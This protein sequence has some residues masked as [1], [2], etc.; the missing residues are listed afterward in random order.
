MK[1]IMRHQFQ[2]LLGTALLGLALSTATFARDLPDFTTLAEQNSPAVVNI[3]TEQKSLLQRK[4]PKGFSA[5]DLPEDSPLNDLFKHFFGEGG[6]D[7]GDRDT[8]SL[9]SGFVV[10]S[11]GYIL[12]N[13]HVVADADEIQV[14]FSDRRTYQAKVI[15]SDRGSDVALIKIEATGLPTVKIGKSNDLKVGEWVL[16]I[17]SPF[18]FDHTVT[19]GI[20]SAKGRSLPSE[21]YVPFIQTDVAINPGNSGGPLINLDGEV[22]GINSQ[23]YSRTGGFMGL[24]FAIPIELA[25]NVADQLREFGRVSRGYLGVLI[26]DVDRNLAESFGMAQ[27]HGALVSRVMPDSPADKAGIKVGDI[28]LAFNGKR[29]LNSSQL[30]PLV[31]TT[32][33]DDKATLLVLR[34]GHERDIQVSVGQL[35][36]Q[37]QA[38]EP[39]PAKAEP[40]QI[41]QIGLVVIDIEPQVREQLGMEGSGGAL[42]GKVSPGPAQDAGLRRGDIVLMFDGVDVKS[43]KHLRELIDKAGDKRTV[44]VL[45]RRGESPMF[46]A[47]R[48]NS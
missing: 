17:G 43:A 30:P 45:V 36:D 8:E 47:L 39:E 44:A 2:L 31:G 14:H 38:A 4:M 1:K 42:V 18:G 29:L 10:S 46:L 25:M 41:E 3:S 24:S 20:V 5:P 9:G 32:R 28:I 12:T 16:A 37:E 13:Y 34:G 26:Q 19:A 33:I 22:V 35:P 23:I 11:D 48:L 40:D 15:G 21:N 27:P 6:D 7:L